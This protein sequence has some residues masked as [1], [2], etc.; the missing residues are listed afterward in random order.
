[1]TSHIPEEI[2]ST[3]EMRFWRKKQQNGRGFDQ[4]RSLLFPVFAIEDGLIRT[5]TSFALTEEV[6][7][8]SL[9]CDMIDREGVRDGE[10]TR[11]AH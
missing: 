9:D 4:P 8:S 3:L 7:V 5:K 1:M 2:D 10:A 6:D 11:R